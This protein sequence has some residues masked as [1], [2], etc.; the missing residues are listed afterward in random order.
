MELKNINE[1]RRRLGLFPV[2]LHSDFDDSGPFVLLNGFKGSFC[3]ALENEHA[4]DSVR[5]IAW[6]SNVGHYVALG[7]ESVEVRRWDRPGSVEKYERQSVADQLEAF[8]EYLERDSPDSSSSVVSHGIRIFRGLRTA[9]GPTVSG[10][11]ALKAFLFLLACASR[12]ESRED[13]DPSRWSLDSE[14]AEHVLSLSDPDWKS[15]LLALR[16]GRPL[17]RLAVNVDLLLRHASGLLFQ[18]AHFEALLPS[19]RQLNFEFSMPEPAKLSASASGI[20]LHFTPPVLARTLVEEAL[21]ELSLSEMPC[22]SIFDP[23][24]GSGEFLREALRQL[25]LLQY[26]GRIELRGWDISEAACSMA[27]F[28]LAWDNITDGSALLDIQNL[29]SLDSAHSWPAGLSL[30]LMNPPFVSWEGMTGDQRAQV[31][32]ILGADFHQKP[33]LAAAF[34]AKSSQTLAPGGVLAT[35]LPASF[36]GAAATSKLRAELGVR[37]SAKLIARLGSHTLFQSALIDPGLYIA[38][39]EDRL[40]PAPLSIWSDFRSH[41]TSA[42]LRSLRKARQLVGESV[43]PVVAD[44][45][46][47][48][49]Q[50]GLGKDAKSWA[51]RPYQQLRL[52][53]RLSHFPRARDLFEIRQG[54]RT[55]LKKAFVISCEDWERLPVREQEFFRPGVLNESLREGT[56]SKNTYVFFPYG[57]YE[58]PDEATLR[59][60]LKTYVRTFLG[61]YREELAVRASISDR[62]WELTRHRNWQIEAKPKLVSSYF[63]DRGSFAWD[64]SGEF[65]VVQGFGWLPRPSCFKRPFL[66]KLALAYLAILNSR[67]FSHLLAATSNNVAGGQWDLSPRFV[68]EMPMPCITDDLELVT[69]LAKFGTRIHEGGLSDLSGDAYDDAVR[70]A[71]GVAD[72]E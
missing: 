13:V 61:P 62:W 41:S 72:Y 40:E 58:I 65:V 15:L 64:S 10:G 31:K 2:P 7:E 21:A 4:S 44:G 42:V 68:G 22:I 39:A 56:L 30:I 53:Q 1:W 35:I 16:E 57:T 71:Y 51:P 70:S 46:S 8:H 11:G 14:A 18:E 43:Y 66:R 48:Y 52:F 28:G 27:R 69:A 59:K 47:I 38:K 5:S 36:F 17:E 12:G 45:F 34:L 19:G 24:C 3:L 49:R 54:A 67:L 60:K 29:D 25:R 37:L 33:D 55:G 23:A 63:G 32:R 6:S 50:P 26:Q 9:L 20:G